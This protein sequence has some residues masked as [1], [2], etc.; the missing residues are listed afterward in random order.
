MKPDGKSPLNSL[1]FQYPSYPFL[2]PPE[3]R[4]ERRKY[5]VVIVGA[6]PVGLTAAL[7]LARR[8]IPVV[9]LDDKATI[10]D[11]SRAICIS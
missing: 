3:M 5:P 10:N 4:G 2:A 9:V 6:G 8:D 11:G 1:Y 7:E